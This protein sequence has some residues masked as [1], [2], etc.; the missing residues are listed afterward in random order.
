MKVILLDSCYVRSKIQNSRNVLTGKI[1]ATLER[2]DSGLKNVMRKS[3]M[4]VMSS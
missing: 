3:S 2:K 1:D 4:P